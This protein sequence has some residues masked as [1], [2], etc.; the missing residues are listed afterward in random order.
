MSGDAHSMAVLFA[1]IC[2]SERLYE[3]AGD[4]SAHRRIATG[5]DRLTAIIDKRG[6]RVVKTADEEILATFPTADAAFAAGSDIHEAG[7][8]DLLPVRAGFHFGPV[9]EDAGDVFGDTV[10]LAARIAG[11][12]QA[13]EVLMPEQTLDRLAPELRRGTRLLD[14][15]TVKGKRHPLNV[16]EIAPP[17][18]DATF[19]AGA[20]APGRQTAAPLHLVY[21]ERTL[22][23]S[24]LMVRFALGR[25]EQNDLVVD[26]S[27]VSRQHAIIEVHRGQFHLTDCSTNGTYVA[28]GGNHPVLLKREGVLLVGAG[29]ISLGRPPGQNAEHLLRFAYG[30]DID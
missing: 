29:H 18:H 11:L 2:D 6:G 12:A 15:V 9:I 8:P 26:D 10:N 20:V 1:I 25:L 5:I 7:L 30:T 14:R 27:M 23:V 3:T 17:T 16:H 28:A 21:R 24:P 4:E 13:G 22:V 19:I